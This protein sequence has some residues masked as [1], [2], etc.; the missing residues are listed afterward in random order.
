M[1]QISAFPI[2]I[3]SINHDVCSRSGQIAWILSS[4]KSLLYANFMA[5]EEVKFG[6]ITI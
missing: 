1:I 5:E 4:Q 2:L 6:I 3:P